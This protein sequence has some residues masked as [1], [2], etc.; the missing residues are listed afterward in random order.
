M[1][2]FYNKLIL[3]DKGNSYVQKNKEKDLNV[4]S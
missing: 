4:S 2:E 1:F 3:K